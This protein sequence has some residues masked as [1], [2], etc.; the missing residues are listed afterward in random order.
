M[1]IVIKYT[2]NI[3]LLAAF[4]FILAG[5][6]RKLSDEAVEP[7]FPS[8]AEIFTDDFIGMG[9]DFYFPFADAKP[10]V[11]SVDITEGFESNSSIRID[12]PNATDPAGGYAGAIFRTEGA[13]RNL[14]QFNALSFYVKA[15]Q[16]V[17]LGDVGFGIDFEGD[18]FQVT[19]NNVNVSTNWSKV[20]I[21]IPDA[22]KLLQE[23]G[24]F[25]FAAGT[26]GTG[27]S[28]YALWFDE[29][30]F[31]NL[32]T[33]GTPRATIFDG[34]TNQTQAFVGSNLQVT[35]LSTVFNLANGQDVTVAAAPSY[36]NFISSDTNVASVN[37]LGQITI[38]S[39][40]T[41]DITAT[42]GGVAAIGK[43]EIGSSGA[44]PMAPTPTRPQAEV[45]SLFSDAYTPAI[46]INFDPR[47]GG[48]NTVTTLVGAAGNQVLDYKANNYTGIMWDLTPIDGST[49]NFLHIDVYV[50][51]ATGPIG[52]QIRDI[53]S[54]KTLET[55]ENTGNPI[56]DDKD[57]RQNISGFVSGEWRSFDI[58]LAGDVA[59]QK[60]NLGAL[61][62]TG[63]PNFIFDNIYFYE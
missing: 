43:L 61:I 11:F 48:S 51:E 12:V 1:K 30:K 16:G 55:D 34:Q 40:G 49:M 23:R 17:S 15:S 58:P 50:Q 14:T 19:T 62:I 63:G 27:G 26:Q 46:G 7:S 42:V 52:I 13:G 36:Y 5:C 54:N 10:D 56:G 41:A 59:S 2:R 53:G 22:S 24:V 57:F 25:W 32:G 31:E 21:P 18:K 9:A 35:G 39:N 20:I 4:V 44:L 37:E 47:F 60:A 29:I 3:S 38:K 6:E 28:G 8:T 45:L 33:I